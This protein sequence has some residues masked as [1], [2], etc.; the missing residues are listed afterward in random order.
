[1][2]TVSSYQAP[3]IETRDGTVVADGTAAYTITAAH[4][5]PNLSGRQHL[6]PPTETLP[7]VIYLGEVLGESE[8]LEALVAGRLDAIARGEIGKSGC[9]P[10]LTWR[11]RRHRL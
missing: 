8:L 9:R 5:S 6:Y 10:R 1:M 2:L 4:A 3:R 11:T 7:Q